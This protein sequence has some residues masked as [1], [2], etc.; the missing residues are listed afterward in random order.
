MGNTRD[1]RV[2]RPSFERFFAANRHKLVRAAVAWTADRDVAERVADE[3]MLAV[4]HQ[5]H[6]HEDAEVLMYRIA[7][8]VLHRI[9]DRAIAD[10]RSDLLDALRCL[11]TRQREAVVL[12]VVCDLDPAVAASVMGV[13]EDA[14]GV[15][16]GRGL[17]ALAAFARPRT[18]SMMDGA[19]G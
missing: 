14:V 10:P 6:R 17:S 5:W 13:S 2:A 3:V 1:R 12:T 11:P 9:A 8:Q 7:R 15:H 4:R 19:A 16:R 18:P